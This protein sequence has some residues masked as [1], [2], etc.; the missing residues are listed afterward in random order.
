[1]ATGS[2]CLR[3]NLERATL[4]GK[5]LAASRRRREHCRRVESDARR[6]NKSLACTMHS[7]IGDRQEVFPEEKIAGQAT[8]GIE[9]SRCTGGAGETTTPARERQVEVVARGPMD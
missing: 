1:M 9:E 4:K 2:T 3:K 6:A 8:V 5:K 7:S